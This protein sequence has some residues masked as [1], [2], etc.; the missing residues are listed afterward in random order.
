MKTDCNLCLEINGTSAPELM[1]DYG[2]LVSSGKNR[3]LESENFVVI[4]SVGPLN[5]SHVMLVPKF[6]ANNF[7]VMSTSEIREGMSLLDRLDEYARRHFGSPLVF[8]ES[9]AGRLS[10]HA[11]GCIIHAHIHCLL[12]SE[13]FQRRLMDE[14]VFSAI[15]AMDY[16]C[17]DGDHGYLWFKDSSGMTRV[18]NRP[19]LPSQFMRYLYALCGKNSLMWNWRRHMNFGGIREV[20]NNY[21]ELKQ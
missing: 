6:H 10:S 21:S 14:V 16:S 15:P 17:I 12:E 5:S 19:M 13:E 9:G 8:F 18:C 11:G 3:I 7:A 4:P 1:G 20:L 2:S